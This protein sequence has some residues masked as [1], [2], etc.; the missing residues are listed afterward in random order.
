M[1]P[2]L[3]RFAL[4]ASAFVFF[5]GCAKKSDAPAPKQ[6]PSPKTH[7]HVEYDEGGYPILGERLVGIGS[8]QI[9]DDDTE[10]LIIPLR[11]RIFEDDPVEPRVLE[12]IPVVPREKP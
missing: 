5:A 9:R 3:R 2:L 11:E 4:L 6:T 12:E 10:E 8:T 1:V 7:P